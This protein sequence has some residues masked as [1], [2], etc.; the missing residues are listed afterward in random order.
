MPDDAAKPNPLA[1][2]YDLGAQQAALLAHN[3]LGSKVEKK[4]RQA[5]EMGDLAP[6]RP[7]IPDYKAQILK[8]AGSV[9][10]TLKE[11]S[12]ASGVRLPHARKTVET[13]ARQGRLRNL[14]KS[15]Q[16]GRW[17][18]SEAVNGTRC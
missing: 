5:A 15:G 16:I 8:A 7:P 4:V 3:R 10:L 18:L 9:P 12:V 1:G 13:L 2:L 17:V 11:L 6:G 14:A